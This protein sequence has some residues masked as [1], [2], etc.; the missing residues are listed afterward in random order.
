MLCF[1]N[2]KKDLVST[3]LYNIVNANNADNNR[4]N[5]KTI[6]VENQNESF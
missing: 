6:V 1:L 4:M 5:A 3:E 2:Q